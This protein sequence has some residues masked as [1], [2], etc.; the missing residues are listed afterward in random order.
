MSYPK[1]TTYRFKIMQ[2]HFDDNNSLN[3]VKSYHFTDP[4]R[5]AFYLSKTVKYRT[6]KAVFKRP[7]T[8]E[9]ALF[10]LAHTISRRFDEVWGVE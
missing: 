9:Q 3:L 10:A 1:A 2:R 6:G 4:N 5:G 7:V 8:Q